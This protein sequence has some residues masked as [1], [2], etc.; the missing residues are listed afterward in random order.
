VTDQK[1]SSSSSPKII[2]GGFSSTAA[3][4]CIGKKTNFALTASASAS[5]IWD[6]GYTAAMANDGDGGTRWNSANGDV[7][8]SWLEL[9]FGQEV[10]FNKTKLSQLDNRIQSYKIQY[11]DGQ[12]KDAYTG[13]VLGSGST[14]V[15]PAVTGTKAR[16]YVVSAASVPSIYEFEVYSAGTDFDDDG[17]V[18]FADLAWLCTDWL[19]ADCDQNCDCQGADVYHDGKV[20]LQDFSVLA[21][22]YNP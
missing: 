8:G 13:G 1:N 7:N 2:L 12:W 6:S 22:E 4:P 20:D 15:F 14:D 10:T 9:D 18:N 11:D 3:E 5:S 16:L 17:R 19:E 21:R